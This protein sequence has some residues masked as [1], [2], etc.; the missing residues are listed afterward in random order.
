[1]DVQIVGAYQTESAGRRATTFLVDGRVAID[2]GCLAAALSR[3]QQRA[4]EAVVLTHYHYDHIRDFPSVAFSRWG[5]PPLPVYCLPEV[6]AVLRSAFFNGVIW[7]QLDELPSSEAPAVRFW[8]LAPYQPVE[9]AGYR[10]TPAPANHSAPTV[11]V[12][13]E[14][15][16]RSLFYTSDTHGSVPGLWERVRPDLLLVEVT[17][18]NRLDAA[19]VNAKHLTPRRLGAELEAFRAIHGTLPRVV[20]IHRNADYDDEIVRELAALAAELGATIEAPE[21]G[22]RYVV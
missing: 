15:D 11:G 22:Q 4:L 10:L 9:V 18:P 12:L 13:I 16:G 2:A 3:E 7:P 14:R 21:D 19:A 8:E 17:F 5:Y 6:R 20:A 1:M